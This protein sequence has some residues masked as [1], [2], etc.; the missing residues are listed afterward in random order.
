[1]ERTG[2]G[3]FVDV[4]MLDGVVSW[5]SIHLGEHLA[6][7]VAQDGGRASLSG[8]LACYRVYRAGDGRYLTVGALE[9]RFWAALCAALGVPELEPE[10]YAPP[11]RQEEIAGRLAEIFA[12]RGRDQWLA[13]LAELDVCVGPV[14]DLAEAVRDPQVAHRGMVA[15]VEGTAVGPGGPIRFD[16]AAPAALRP[17]PGLGEHT[18]AVLAESGLDAAAVAELRREGVV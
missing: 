15:T 5:L 14:N 4:S 1:R 3:R 18:D 8:G 9:P 17:A 7:G 10:Q 13:D 16:G 2:E 11:E 12:T 6:T